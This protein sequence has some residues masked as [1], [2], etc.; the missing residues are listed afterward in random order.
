MDYLDQVIEL[1]NEVRRTQQEVIEKAAQVVAQAIQAGHLIYVFGASHASIL[2][3]ELFYRAGGLVPVNPI[4]APGLTTD[5]RP[6]TLT[7]RL[8]RLPGLGK[9][10]IAETPIQPGDVLIVHSVSGRNAVSVEAAQAGR[11]KGAFVI[12]VTS[13]AYSKAVKPRQ[14]GMPRLFEAADLVLDTFAP[15]GDALV[16]LPGLPQRAGP[17]STITGAAILNAVMVRAAILLLE[18]TGDA[19]VFMSANLDEGEE[20]NQKWLEFYRG[21]L[22]Y[23]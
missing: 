2:A 11:D 8:E 19:P 21:R 17:A 5:V 22:T 12:A 18:Q 7:T 9:G 6:M 3:Q 1:M 20:H 16:E 4:L 13:L 15:V 10:I 23:L 14:P